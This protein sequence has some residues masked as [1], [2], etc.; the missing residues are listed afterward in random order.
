MTTPSAATPAH[1][2]LRPSHPNIPGKDGTLEATLA[3]SNG[4]PST[5]NIFHPQD[6][7]PNPASPSL[8]TLFRKKT[9]PL[10]PR[11]SASTE[12]FPSPVSHH[13]MA[14]HFTHKCLHLRRL[15][16]HLQ[17]TQPNDCDLDLL[18]S[19]LSMTV[20]V[21]LHPTTLRAQF[22]RSEMYADKLHLS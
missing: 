16:K 2:G 13:K 20:Q 15:Q 17:S 8:H 11:S 6:T 19:N 7:T 3:A 21:K 22:L 18:H 14:K 12:L 9:I 10:P 5:D 1:G 4:H